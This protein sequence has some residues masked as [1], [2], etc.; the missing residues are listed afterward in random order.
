M[1]IFNLVMQGE[2]KIKIRF[3][4]RLVISSLLFLSFFLNLFVIKDILTAGFFFLL[5]DL[6]LG[7]LAIEKVSF[8]R[9]NTF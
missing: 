6:A 9:K 5:F 8:D 4:S 7:F 3:W 2:K 1:F